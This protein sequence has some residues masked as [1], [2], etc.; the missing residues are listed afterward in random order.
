VLQQR[1]GVG[2]SR[3]E[4]SQ[5]AG[6]FGLNGRLKFRDVQHQ[7][8]LKLIDTEEEALADAEAARALGFN[9]LASQLE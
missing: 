2:M 8:R 9:L 1:S 6:C 5:Q 4:R 3:Q 7:L